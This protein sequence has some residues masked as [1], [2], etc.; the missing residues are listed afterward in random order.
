VEWEHHQLSRFD[1][2]ISDLE[3][4]SIVQRLSMI[5]PARSANGEFAYLVNDDTAD[6]QMQL[7]C[8]SIVVATDATPPSSGQTADDL[9]PRKCLPS[10]A[11]Q[12]K[13]GA[14]YVCFSMVT[15]L[16]V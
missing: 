10:V 12:S 5:T 14:W 13:S 8:F 16:R 15:I 1:I 9:C 6:A 11:G 7:L 3:Q 2:I 4:S